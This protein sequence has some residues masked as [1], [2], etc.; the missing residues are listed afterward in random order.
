MTY[1]PPRFVPLVD[2]ALA[3]GLTPR[4]LQRALK[5]VEV[6]EAASWRGCRPIVRIQ[7]GRGG[8]SG[9]QFEL[10][11]DS[12]PLDLQ[13][14]FKDRYGEAPPQLSHGPKAQQERSFWF[15]VISPALAHPKGSRERGEAIREA[16]A[17]E[18]WRPGRKPFFADER[19]IHRKIADYE[20]HGLAGLSRAK[21]ADAGSDKVILSREW[22][23]AV[24]LSDAEKSRIADGMRGY[25]GGLI[26]KGTAPAMIRQFAAVELARR[27]REAGCDLG[28]DAASVCHLPKMFIEG[29]RQRLQKATQ[30]KRDRKGFDDDQPRGLRT[31]ASKPMMVLY[32]DVH[33]VDIALRRPDGSIVH[34]RM[35]GWLDDATRRFRFDLV[36]PQKGKGIGNR[37]VI[38]SFI[39]TVKAWGAPEVLYV[40]NGSEYGFADMIDDA[41]RLVSGS[42]QRA[43]KR[44]LPYNASAKPIEGIFKVLENSYWK[45]IPGW[46][47]GDRVNKK[48]ANVGNKIE[49]FPGSLEQFH[50]LIANGVDTYNWIPQERGKLKGR[51]PNQAYE[52]AIQAGWTMTEVHADAFRL[53]FSN[54]RQLTLRQGAVSISGQRWTCPELVTWLE[55]KITALIPKYEDWTRIPLLDPATGELVGMAEPQRAYGPT[56]AAGA[57]EAGKAKREHLAAVLKLARSVPDVDPLRE[58]VKFLAM[59]APSP[60]APIGA[61]IGASDDAL[62]MLAAMNETPKD[63]GEREKREREARVH[64]QIEAGKDIIERLRRNKR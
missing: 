45:G 62:R 56:E 59:Q 32:G 12:L 40:D 24:N 37:H 34:A 14:R 63:K 50:A 54:K 31:L 38:Q 64:E 30:L 44:A 6:S 58:Q 57:I 35:I 39:N 3:V 47:G 33:P 29:E 49:P 5:R 13:L 9:R 42:G 60:V 18:R 16:A 4:A 7:H 55:P 11:V 21:R 48:T 25:V 17:Q 20:A 51:S 15:H 43:I 8:R 1:T 53:A 27:T 41:L 19:T 2:L 46:I 26:V 28:A 22:D 36:V 52:Q 23:R 61:T 10:R